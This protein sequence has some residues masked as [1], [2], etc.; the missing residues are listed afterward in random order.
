MTLKDTCGQVLRGPLAS[1]TPVRSIHL[2]ETSA[3]LRA[4][5]EETLSVYSTTD[6][7]T[8]RAPGMDIRWHETIDDVPED[9]SGGL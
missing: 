7:S 3:T 9:V 5:Q 6:N 1:S 2:V 8:S 4:K